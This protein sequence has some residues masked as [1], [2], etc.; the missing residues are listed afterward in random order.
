MKS[1][2]KPLTKYLGLFALLLLPVMAAYAQ[3]EPFNAAANVA[4]PDEKSFID[5]IA[6]GGWAMWPLGALSML[7]LGLIIFNF[8][9]IRAKNFI[10]AEATERL[11]EAMTNLE[12]DEAIGICDANKTPLTGIV[13]AGLERIKGDAV[14]PVQIEKAAEAAAQDELATPYIFVN[15]LQSVASVSPMVGLLGTVS[16]MIKAFQNIAVAGLGQ[17]DKMAGNISEALI[18]TA[19]GLI[20]AIPALLFYFYFK[21][22]FA[23]ISSKVTRT[24][25]NL[26]FGLMHSAQS[27]VVEE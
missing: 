13:K 20:V 9:N 12:I 23:K 24:A 15:Y 7:S 6:A 8:I 1:P 4:A 25:D 27:G 22:K 17:P 14:D 2:K 16:G 18:T 26:F 19:S 21:N 10:P 3:T 5:L 11:G